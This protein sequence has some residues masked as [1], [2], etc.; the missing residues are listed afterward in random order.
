MH[1]AEAN[2]L[3]LFRAYRPGS[4]WFYRLSFGGF[5]KRTVSQSVGPS[6]CLITNPNRRDPFEPGLRS[7]NNSS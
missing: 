4:I 1:C 2:A 6:R 3:A 7:F 5:A